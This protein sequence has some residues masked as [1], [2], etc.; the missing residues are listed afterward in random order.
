[1]RISSWAWDEEDRRDDYLIKYYC[2]K[3]GIHFYLT[4]LQHDIFKEV[5]LKVLLGNSAGWLA[6][7]Q[8]SY[9][10][11]LEIHVTKNLATEVVNNT[12]HSL[13]RLV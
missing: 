1:M 3:T 7:T 13:V 10:P 11:G 2:G 5:V 4:I 8:L 6:D 12:V 9:C